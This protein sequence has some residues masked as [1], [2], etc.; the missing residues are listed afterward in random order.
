MTGIL[1]ERTVFAVKYKQNLHASGS[2]G[3][4]MSM[5]TMLPAIFKS[6]WRIA[7]RM[8][9]GLDVIFAH[10]YDSDLYMLSKEPG[11]MNW[12]VTVHCKNGK[13]HLSSVEKFVA[14]PGC[15]AHKG[16]AAW[17]IEYFEP[18]KIEIQR[19]GQKTVSIRHPDR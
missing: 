2:G 7:K 6:G 19:P 16:E 18:E 5:K 10:D 4:F 15:A 3:L 9:T 1:S 12:T 13:K 11:A 17:L 14:Y 8:T